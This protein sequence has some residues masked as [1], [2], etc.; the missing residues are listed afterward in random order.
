MKSILTLALAAVAYLVALASPAAALPPPQK[1][2]ANLPRSAFGEV[3]VT[4]PQPEALMMFPYGMNTRISSVTFVATASSSGANGIVTISADAADSAATLFSRRVIRYAPGRGSMAIFT[5][6]FTTGVDASTQTIGAF[7]TD[8]QDGFGF[9]FNGST[10]GVVRINGGTPTWYSSSTWNID[11]L[12]GT[13]QSKMV[14]DPTKGNVYRIQWQWLGFGQIVFEVEDQAT[15]EFIPVHKIRYANTATATSIQNPSLHLLM[16]AQNHANATTVSV[17]SASMGGYIQGMDLSYGIEFSTSTTAVGVGTSE[18][19]LLS[20]RSSETVPA[21]PSMTNRVSSLLEFVSLFCDSTAKPCEIRI[22][23]G[24]TLTAPVWEDA[25]TANSVVLFDHNASGFAGGTE[26]VSLFVARGESK[27][28]VVRDLGIDLL[29]GEVLTVVGA[30][31]SG[32][33][34][35][36]VGLRWEEKR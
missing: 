1:V 16:F 13:G 5:G 24:A 10:F 2:D 17:K 18:T 7:S 26:V 23:R 3:L 21:M 28:I 27:P 19:P 6:I 11:R 8:L 22:L 33:T 30:T 36:G 15:G 9:G 4:E 32:S 34:D 12:D 14:I 35:I 25:E 20:L 29:P 31:S